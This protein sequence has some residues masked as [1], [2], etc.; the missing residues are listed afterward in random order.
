MNESVISVYDIESSFSNR[1]L[2]LILF[3]TEQCNFRCKYCYEKFEIG[4][5]DAWIVS[6]IKKLIS[7]RSNDVANL[8]ISWFGGEPLAAKNIIFDIMEHAN[9]VSKDDSF[10]ISDMT[11]NGYLLDLDTFNSL[12][13]LGVKKYQITLDGPKQ[14]HDIL[15]IRADGAGT[16]DRIWNNLLAMKSS[17]ENFLINIRVHASLENFEILPEFIK[18]ID[19]NFLYD[20]RF[21]LSL[22]PVEK[23]G[24]PNDDSLDTI[25]HEN[26]DSIL[27]SIFKKSGIR[28]PEEQYK[29]E[30]GVCYAAKPNSFVIR[31]TGDVQKCTLGLYDEKN[32][33]G[34]LS[35]NGDLNL[36]ENEVLWR[37]G[38]SD[39][40]QKSLSCPYSV[41]KK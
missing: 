37:K 35:I 36:N 23:W 28:F 27:R 22:I 33:V 15:R 7:S 6:A 1:F 32:N 5:M 29:L 2:S 31:A 12:C 18:K 21:K 19:N 26:H 30:G 11:T 39:F 14:N 4:K 34:K 38:W 41:M 20:E 10:I 24:G 16:F 3:P 8:S 40:D 9:S 13:Q 17:D 25:P